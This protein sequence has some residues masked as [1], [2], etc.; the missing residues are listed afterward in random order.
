VDAGTRLSRGFTKLGFRWVNSSLVEIHKS[1]PEIWLTRRRRGVLA[2]ML[3]RLGLCIYVDM[4]P[5][6]SKKDGM[7][8]LVSEMRSIPLNID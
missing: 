4:E 3:C 1:R 2:I 5:I 7:R 8:L 6:S